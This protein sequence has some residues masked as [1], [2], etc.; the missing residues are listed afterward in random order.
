MNIFLHI[1]FAL[2]V[3][4]QVLQ[5]SDMGERYKNVA[6]DSERGMCQGTRM[7]F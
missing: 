1:F 4:V 2:V 6:T 7:E 5:T 3:H